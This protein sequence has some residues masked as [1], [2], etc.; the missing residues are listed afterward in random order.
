MATAVPWTEQ[1]RPK[2]ASEIIG[3]DNAMR[4][5]KSLLATYKQRSVRAAV[6]VGPTGT[7]KSA[8]VHALANDMDLEVMEVNASDFRNKEG[9]QSIVGSAAG[10][11]SLFAKGKVILVDEIDG[12]SGQKDRGGI[13]ALAALL[14]TTLH[15]IIMTTN[16][17]DDPKFKALKKKAESIEFSP[18]GYLDVFAIL[19][20]ICDGEKISYEEMSLK[21]VA[22]RCGGDARAAINDLQSAVSANGSL[23][24]EAIDSISTRDR[25]AEITH[26]LVRV[27]KTTKAEIA[28]DAFLNLE[29]DL[30]EAIL[31]MDWNI[32]REYS[33]PADLDRAYR[34][35]SSADVFRGRI[36][37]WQHW[38]FL[39]YVSALSSV[40]VALAKDEKNPAQVTYQRTGRLLKIW[41]ANQKNARRKTI[42]AVVASHTHTSQREAVSAT[43]PFLQYIFRHDKTSSAAMALELDLDKDQVA[44]LQA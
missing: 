10:Q 3:Q 5:L 36:R 8:A 29:I 7:G 14:D 22:R 30:D 39:V 44:W 12:L 11:A 41:I 31:W 17:I 1:Y 42:G 6:L 35:L 24:K 13:P 33:S 28:R 9:I 21:T 40:G 43:V 27:F 2:T 26:A 37:R 15:P 4:Q 25:E 32:P 38:R 34:S 19:K 23:D 20:R 18:M 16:A